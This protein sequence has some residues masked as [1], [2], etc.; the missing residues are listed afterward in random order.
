MSRATTR[1]VVL[2]FLTATLSAGWACRVMSQ[3]CDANI[4]R[5]SLK[6]ALLAVSIYM[7]I[8][9]EV[10][11]VRDILHGKP[12][13]SDIVLMGLACLAVAGVKFLLPV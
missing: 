2:V 9:C 10:K 8:L 7:G 13:W 11:T 6:A 4:P 5:V 1:T 3:V 12:N